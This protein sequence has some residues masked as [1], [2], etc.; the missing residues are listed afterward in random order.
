MVT[1]YR[2]RL[3]ARPLNCHCG[4]LI[5]R[6][7]QRTIPYL[8]FISVAAHDYAK[9]WDPIVHGFA[10]AAFPNFEPDVQTVLWLVFRSISTNSAISLFHSCDIGS[11]LPRC[12][13][14][15]QRTT[16]RSSTCW[17]HRDALSSYAMVHERS[18]I[19][20]LGNGDDLRF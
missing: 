7:H 3:I 4:R 13:N 11:W 8:L 14:V 1:Y 15:S 17:I 9:C 12:Y 19:L 6:P 2:G 16:A 10:V 5:A 18:L 20:W